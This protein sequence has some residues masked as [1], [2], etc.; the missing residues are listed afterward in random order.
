MLIV[1]PTLG[2]RADYLAQTLESIVSQS[3]AADIVLVAPLDAP[4]VIEAVTRFG[5]SVIADPGSLPSAIN[6]G[7]ASA[8]TH[9]RY[10]NWLGDDDLLTPGSLAA[11]RAALEADSGRVLAYGACSYID[12]HGRD[13]WVSKA[14]RWAERILAWGPDLIPQPGMLVRREAW[15][16]VGGVDE[17]LKFAF[18]LDLLLKLKRVG[19]LVDVGTVVSSFRWHSES[20][21]VSDRTMSLD[22]SEAVKRRYL[23]PNAR[24]LSWLWE[25]PVRGATRLAAREVTRRAR[26]LGV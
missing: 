18:D 23:S 21:T 19:T 16:Q 24:H 13:L 26:K 17:S 15:D 14:G 9:H 12:E 5:I 11:T 20:L 1:I 22:E 10:V 2:R 6:A 4:A 7:M 3:V 25:K 8:Q